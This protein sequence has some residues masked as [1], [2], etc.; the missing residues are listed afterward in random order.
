MADNG[1]IS[2]SSPAMS[3]SS[4]LLWVIIGLSGIW[5]VVSGLIDTNIKALVRKGG[6]GNFKNYVGI[7]LFFIILIMLSLFTPIWMTGLAALAVY[8][9]VISFKALITDLFSEVI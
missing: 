8:L 6:K 3:L 4:L 1:Q 5:I 9:F 7:V 2:M